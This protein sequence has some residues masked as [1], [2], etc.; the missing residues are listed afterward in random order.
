LY[1]A[2]AVTFTD[3]VA[4]VSTWEPFRNAATLHE[5]L[6]RVFGEGFHRQEESNLTTWASAVDILETAQGL[7]V[8]ADLPNVDPKDLDRKSVV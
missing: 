5:Q 1:H 4:I 3:L 7:I 2:V 6:D 8:K